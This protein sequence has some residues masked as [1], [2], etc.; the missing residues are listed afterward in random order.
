MASCCAPG[1][2]DPSGP[3]IALPPRAITA[4]VLTG[5]TLAAFL[6]AVK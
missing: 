4:R 3:V 1:V 5:A 2:A 6:L